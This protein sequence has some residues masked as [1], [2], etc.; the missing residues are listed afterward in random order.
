MLISAGLGVVGAYAV[1]MFE[2]ITM[3][4]Y[5]DYLLAAGAGLG[6]AFLLPNLEFFKSSSAMIQYAMVAGGAGF[7]VYMT[8]K[9]IEQAFPSIVSYTNPA[10]S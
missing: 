9:Q 10:A 2:G 6:A 3:D 5:S 1:Y 8:H 4:K 7:L